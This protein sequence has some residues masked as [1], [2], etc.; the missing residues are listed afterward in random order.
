M[1]KSKESFPVGC[2]AGCPFGSAVAV[3]DLSDTGRLVLA[4]MVRACSL[5]FRELCYELGADV[6]YGPE[7]VDLK[8]LGGASHRVTKCGGRVAEWVYDKDGSSVFSTL[9]ERTRPVIFQL[10]TATA[11]GAV[12]AARAVADDVD[13]LDVN[14]G[15]CVYFSTQGGMG[16]ALAESPDTVREIVHSLVREFGHKKTVSA[17]IRLRETAAAT[18]EFVR[19][20]LVS[21]GCRD[22]AVHARRRD[23]G[24][25]GPVHWDE[26]RRVR[27]LLAA[28]GV[29]LVA[30]GGV[31]THSDIE[32]IRAATGIADVMIGKAAMENPS[33]FRAG[34][35]AER[36]EMIRRFLRLSLKYSG[37]HREAKFSVLEMLKTLPKSQRGPVIAMVSRS[38]SLQ[39]LCKIF[40]VGDEEDEDGGSENDE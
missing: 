17:K 24:L 34:P 11:E 8:L 12:E 10:G 6:C 31:S 25:T 30:N 7:V 13:G 16:S 39:D 4:P 35:L 21:A 33:V 19:E 20:A 2:V 1:S 14:L 32:R 3:S 23:E 18:A 15:C 29:R 26:L 38:K 40:D 28:D 22:V 27:E 36:E 37:S 9:T 5:P